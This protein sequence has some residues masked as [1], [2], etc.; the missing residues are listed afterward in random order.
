M[1]PNFKE[2]AV[3]GRIV[4]VS[5]DGKYLIQGALIDLA[6]RQNLT[7]TSE[8]VLRRGVGVEADIATEVT[9]EDGRKGVLSARLKIRDVSPI[10]APAVLDKAA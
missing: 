6:T 2:V 8:A 9:F 7:E 1:I 10:P 5:V 3:S 4:Y